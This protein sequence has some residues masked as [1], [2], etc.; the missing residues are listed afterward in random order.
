MKPSNRLLQYPK[1][2]FWVWD[3]QKKILEKI[4]KHLERHGVVNDSSAQNNINTKRITGLCT[5]RRQRW[6]SPKN[7][8]PVGFN[9]A[10]LGV[11]LSIVFL[12]TRD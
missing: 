12:K 7:V 10:S 11:I 6:P 5:S 4:L 9:P 1:L 3:G 8:D 2:L